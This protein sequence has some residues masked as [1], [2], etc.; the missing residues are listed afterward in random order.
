MESFNGFLIIAPRPTLSGSPPS[1]IKISSG[2]KRYC[3]ISCLVAKI[4]LT[5][6]QSIYPLFTF[7]TA[8]YGTSINSVSVVLRPFVIPETISAR[9]SSDFSGH[10][11][12]FS[13]ISP[14]T[15][16]NR[17]LTSSSSMA[18]CSRR[19]E[20]TA[21]TLFKVEIISCCS[22]LLCKLNSSVL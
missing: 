7:E 12:E 3:S 16:T 11:R 6:V 22:V 15:S 5:V 19:F 9:L 8:I 20:I 21:S 4:V 18:S 17:A 1:V 13:N 14:N 2:I 10:S